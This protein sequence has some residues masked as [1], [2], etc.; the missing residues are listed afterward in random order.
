MGASSSDFSFLATGSAALA[1]VFSVASPAGDASWA[2]SS[3]AS[4]GLLTA[5]DAPPEV[6]S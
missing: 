5:A 3:L 6:A 2:L 1:S 4:A